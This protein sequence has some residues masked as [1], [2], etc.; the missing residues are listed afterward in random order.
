[1]NIAKR[2]DSFFDRWLAGVNPYDPKRLKERN[3]EPVVIEESGVRKTAAKVFIVAFLAFAVWAF[4]APIDQGVAIPGNV[5]VQGNRKLVQHP[6]GGVVTQILVKEG[7]E[8]KEGDI[9]IKVNPLNSEANL[10]TAQLQYINLLATESRL[11]SE[12]DGAP[13]INWDPE[14]SKFKNDKRVTEAKSIQQKLFANRAA[15]YKNAI[16]SKK[17]E[18][19]TLTVEA[20][21]AAQLAK[22]GFMPQA[23]ASAVLRSKVAAEAAYSSLVNGRQAEIGKELAE[24]QKNREALQQRVQSLAFDADLNNIKAPVSGVITGLKVNTVGGV[25]SGTQTLMEVVP[26]EEI[27]IIEAKVPVNL[28]DKVKSGMEADLRFSAFNQ[29]T[30]PVVP[31]KVTLVGADKVTSDKTV[32]PTQQQ[33]Q[34]EYYLAR[35]ETTAE[36]QKMLGENQ[37]QPGMPV[38]VIVKSGE[39]NFFSYVVK[40]LTDSFSRAFLN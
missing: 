22:E 27:L 29:R 19:D 17:V 30:T 14:L 2:I 10:T 3:L 31:G 28:I 16:S 12:R 26:K 9:L 34:N 40:P 18:V 25:I 20:N 36:G 23:Q 24:T 13:A 39:R 38:E 11:K 33:N 8:V 7:Q 15:D 1:M 35:V 21:N 37:I 5:T 6:S 32:D 4:V